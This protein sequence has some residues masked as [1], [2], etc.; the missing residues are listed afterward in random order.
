MA[1]RLSALRA[2]RT[3]PP[4]FFLG[5]LVLISVRCW[6]NSRAIARPEGLGKLE[7]I[8]LIGEAILRPSGLWHSALTTTLPL[9][10]I[11]SLLVPFHS[12]FWW[13]QLFSSVDCL[14][15]RNLSR[16]CRRVPLTTSCLIG[17]VGLKATASNH[18]NYE[19]ICHSTSNFH[20]ACAL[21]PC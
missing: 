15:F 20:H 4:G 3:L 5:F 2:G 19:L 10:L 14:L 18:I 11:M 7:K 16:A 13:V 9:F 6:V 12:F 8:H 21:S 17:I 1:A